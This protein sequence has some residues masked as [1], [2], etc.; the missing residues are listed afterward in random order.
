MRELLDI[1]DYVDASRDAYERG[2]NTERLRI[3]RDLHDDVSVHLLAGLRQ[4]DVAGAQQKM[5]E[6]M[7]EIRTLVSGLEGDQLSLADICGELR[8]ETQQRLDAVDLQLD[9]PLHDADLGGFRLPYAQYKNFMSAQREI[10]SNIIRHAGA[11][12]V[13][14]FLTAQENVLELT[15]SDD[16]VGFGAGG[17]ATNAK[18]GSHG[19]ANI[20]RRMQGIGGEARFNHTEYGTSITL[21]LPLPTAGHPV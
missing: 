18:A 16:G 2:V 12:R 7:A 21:R 6:A 4:G 10:V 9:W 13:Q 1:L 17:G 19:L 3:A 5:R 15:V 14:V 20:Q 11:T 8:H